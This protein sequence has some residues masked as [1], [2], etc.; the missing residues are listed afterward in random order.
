MTET[1][2]RNV[3]S[4]GPPSHVKKKPTI[5]AGNTEFYT[6]ADVESLGFYGVLKF[7]KEH[8]LVREARYTIPGRHK[9]KRMGY[10]DRAG[11]KLIIAHMR[12]AQGKLEL[13]EIEKFLERVG[14]GKERELKK[15]RA[16]FSENSE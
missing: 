4:R 16:L 5:E 10:V 13:R 7:A 12:A 11:L 6:I 3:F 8:G 2:K 14:K 1:L 15:L 9:I